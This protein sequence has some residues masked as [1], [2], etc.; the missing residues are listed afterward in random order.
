M[1]ILDFIAK[2]LDAGQNT[3]TAV[4]ACLVDFSKAFN[5]MDHNVIVTILS[6]L[7]VPTCA[8]KL[9]ISYLSNRRM[10]V[11]YNGATSLDQ[12][13]PGGGPQGGLLTVILFNLQVNLAGAPCPMISSSISLPL[14][15]EPV[16]HPVPCLVGPLP[17]CHERNITLKKKYVDDLSLLESIDLKAKLIK[18]KP[19]F[20]PCN[21]HEQAGLILP[22]G[23]SVLQH[24][25]QD[26]LEFTNQNRMKINTKKT[27]VIPF[28]VSKKFDFLPQ[29]NFPGHEPLEVIYT[30]K[31]LGVTLSTDL[32][33]SPHIADITAR[34]TKKLWIL[35]QFKSLGGQRE[36][37]LNLYQLRVR[38]TLEF[39][40]PVFNSGLSQELSRK[41][42]MVQKKAF[43]IILGSDYVSY[44]NA[45]TSLNQQ[46][47]DERRNALTLNF[48][49][50]CTKSPK[51]SHMFPL[52][53]I[54][55][56]NSR[57]NKKY[58]EF[59]CRTSRYFNSPVPFMAR[60]LNK[61]N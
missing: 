61:E 34:A 20:G 17:I 12:H 43:A 47:L 27:K 13:I 48:A 14:V 16:L 50:K 58:K 21:I 52:N 38:S 23:Q 9:V 1:Q 31:L 25:L 39:A 56:E 54:S 5:R 8:I 15:R 49:I 57:H 46:R 42:E 36:Q 10:C 32:S 19:T 40:A 28:N 22:P 45:L 24:Q 35:I 30:T 60:L 44:E 2:K 11:R 3:P 37:L 59:Q 55:R 33:W 4:L 6:D 51:H 7:N 29:V 26:L 41:V 53:P 18:A